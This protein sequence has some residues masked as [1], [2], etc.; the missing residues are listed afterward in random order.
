MKTYNHAFS[1]GFSVSGSTDPE[2][3]KITSAEFRAAIEARM[4]DLDSSGDLEWVEAIGQP[5][6][7]HEEQ[8]IG[9]PVTGLSA[10]SSL[11]EQAG[12]LAMSQCC[13]THDGY[14]WMQAFREL[15]DLM[16]WPEPDTFTAAPWLQHLSLSELKEH[17]ECETSAILLQL[18][19]A[20]E[21]GKRAAS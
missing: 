2:G 16:E 9:D 10:T 4:D 17:V 8:P 3:E 5:N 20:Y 13:I 6:D 11:L 7:T 21:M 18:E 15:Y 12:A 1:L 14:T 19:A